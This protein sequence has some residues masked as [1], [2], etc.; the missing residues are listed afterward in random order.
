MT[1]PIATSRLLKKYC[2]KLVLNSSLY[3]SREGCLGSTCFPRV[4]ISA[5]GVI[6]VMNIQA[7]GKRTPTSHAA[8]RRYTGRNRHHRP[9]LA[10]ETCVLLKRSLPVAVLVV[11]RSHS[12]G[13]GECRTLRGL[14]GTRLAAH[15]GR[16]PCR[17]RTIGSQF[18]KQTT[19]PSM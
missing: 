16:P 4:G 14:R 7:Y 13:S 12:S 1:T 10:A 8:S 6:D 15:R 9:P 5:G 17:S 18:D 3:P 11:M 19:A 2:T